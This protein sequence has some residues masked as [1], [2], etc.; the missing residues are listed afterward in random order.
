M[1]RISRCRGLS[2][3]L[4]GSVV[5]VTLKNGSS[6]GYEFME[7]RQLSGS[8]NEPGHTVPDALADGEGR[9]LRGQV[10]TFDGGSARRMYSIMEMG[11]VCLDF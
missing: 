2:E 1:A 7:R 6:Y 9:L 8:V 3:K 10:V 5:L 11:N 4:A